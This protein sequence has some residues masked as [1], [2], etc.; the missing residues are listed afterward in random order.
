M[1][2]KNLFTSHR[3]YRG[4]LGDWGVLAVGRARSLPRAHP[5]LMQFPLSP[6]IVL[7]LRSLHLLASPLP[8]GWFP[9]RPARR[10]GQV[11]KHIERSQ[12]CRG[13][14]MPAGCCPSLRPLLCGGE[15]GIA[16]FPTSISWSW[17]KCNGSHF[18][19]GARPFLQ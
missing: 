15:G 1:P 8:V 17:V 3:L 6:I 2:R 5:L 11:E 16:V 9:R 18:A 14:G 12:E 10:G 19:I 4:V 13:A 7:E